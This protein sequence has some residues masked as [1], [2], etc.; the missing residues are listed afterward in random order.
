MAS[1]FE[2]ALQMEVDGRNYY[3]NL[4]GQATHEGVRSILLSLADDEVKHYELFKRMME[5][6]APAWTE[7]PSLKLSLNVFQSI[8]AQRELYDHEE[9]TPDENNISLIDK[10]IKVESDSYDLYMK[11]A[12]EVTNEAQKAIFVKIA[13]E[14]RLHEK[15]LQNVAQFLK[16]PLTWIDNAEFSHIGDEP[17]GAGYS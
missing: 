15:L 12:Q 16:R 4:A 11:K 6:E 13:N 14:E 10:A 5:G 9:F 3:Q 1:I 17:Y 2:F 7:T 8:A